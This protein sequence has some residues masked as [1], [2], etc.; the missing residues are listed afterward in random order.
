MTII[1]KNLGGTWL[2]RPALATSMDTVKVA[3]MCELQ[4]QR[5]MT[6]EQ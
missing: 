6:P 3:D 5:C 4:A 2:P 1:S